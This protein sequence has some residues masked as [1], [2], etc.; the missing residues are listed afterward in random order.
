MSMKPTLNQKCIKTEMYNIHFLFYPTEKEKHT[1][2]TSILIYIL[3]YYWPGYIL[4]DF[5]LRCFLVKTLVKPATNMPTHTHT[6]MCTH[7]CTHTHTYTHTHTH[8]H[9]QTHT[10]THTNEYYILK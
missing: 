5:I 1:H 9:T 3:V 6:H 8:T 7:A 4:E 2:N 10:H